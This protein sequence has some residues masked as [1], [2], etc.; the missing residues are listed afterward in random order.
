MNTSKQFYTIATI[1]AIAMG[2]LALQSMGNRRVTV[3]KPAVIAFVD[4]ERV[5][6]SLEERAQMVSNKDLLFGIHDDKITSRRQKISNYDNEIELYASRSTKQIELLWE[7]L[8]ESHELDNY[9]LYYKQK[10][11]LFEAEATQEL[12][13]KIKQTSAF[14]AKQN[15]WD[16]VYVNDAAIAMPEGVNPNILGEIANRRVLYA[17]VEFDVTDQLI[18]YMNAQYDEMAVR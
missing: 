6:N 18:E 8:L 9:K 17:N 1:I 7:Q 4:L 2:G 15:G 11:I 5:I 16:I 12:Y 13:D 10:L 3:I 14:L